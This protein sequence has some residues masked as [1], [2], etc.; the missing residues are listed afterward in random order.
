MALA[1]SHQGTAQVASAQSC[2]PSVTI[3]ANDTV[4]V[5]VAD[6]NNSTFTV[7]DTGGSVYTKITGI[8]N[9]PAVQVFATAAS[10]ALASTSVTAT[11]AAAAERISVAVV[12]YT[13][14]KALG[15]SGTNTGSSTGPTLS[16]GTQD[17]GNFIV[18]GF[19]WFNSAANSASA[20]VGNLR[21]NAA[22]SATL[23]GVA[24]ADNTPAT[25]LPSNP[26]TDTITLGTSTTWPAVGVELRTGTANAYNATPLL[27]NQPQST[28]WRSLQTIYA[29]TTSL[30]IHPQKVVW[31][32]RA[33]G[34]NSFLIQDPKD[35]TVLLQ[36]QSIDGSYPA[37][38]E[39]DFEEMNVSWRDFKVPTLTSGILLIYYNNKV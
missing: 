7:T 3:N 1:Y 29:S 39:Y 5:F 8:S 21:A 23:T 9:T 26:V 19:G 30:G 20:S 11:T 35:S 32:G 10:S 17:S 18:A 13:G 4:L 14:V 2:N 16:L 27:V 36:G 31:S 33:T 37:D 15:I 34:T 6:T 12:T 25:G 28:G 38:I 22:A 24:A